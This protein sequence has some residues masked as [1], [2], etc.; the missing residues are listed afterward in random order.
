MKQTAN[1]HLF[2][3][4]F[5]IFAKIIRYQMKTTRFLTAFLCMSLLFLSCNRDSTSYQ[6][7]LKVNTNT[8]PELVFDRYEDV[9]FQLDTARFQE[10]LMRVQQDYLPFLGGDLSDPEAVNYLK[11]FAVDDFSLLLYSKVKAHYPELKDVAAMVET[12]YRHFNYYYPEIVLPEKVFTC[13]SGVNPEIPPVIVTDQ[14]LVI[15]LDWY[16]EDDEVYE[17]IGM[18]KY[19]SERTSKMALVKDLGQQL[20]ETF[21]QAD[22]RQTD[23][24]AEMVETGRRDLFVEAMYPEITDEV[25][26]GYNK[27][28]LQWVRENEGNLWADIVGTQTLYS[29]DF[30]AFRTFF[31]DGPFTNEYSY[32]AP[33]RLGEYIGLQIVRSYFASHE[34]S[35][36]NLMQDNDLQGIFLDSGYKPKKY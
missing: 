25:L 15:S 14:G 9:L 10:E 11:G 23:L 13:V 33:P 29:S 2:K 12:V 35:L 4:Q 36:R 32:D 1:I 18:P 24:L 28:Q 16:L 6:K 34:T 3:K 22:R 21:V 5:D 30:E 7:K 8:V 20:Y 19:R 31:A 26:L 17:L 27:D